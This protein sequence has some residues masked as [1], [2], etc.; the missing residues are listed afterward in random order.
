MA[1]L[2]ELSAFTFS[3]VNAVR[4]PSQSRQHTYTVFWHCGQ[5]VCRKTFLFLHTISEKR[6]KNLKS[7][8]TRNG[9]SPRTHG[10]T[11]RRPTPSA[12]LTH[13]GWCSTSPPTLRHTPFFCQDESLGTRE[14]ISS[15][16]HRARQRG[17]C[18]SHTQSH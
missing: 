11:R 6:L 5:R 8:L 16:Y 2:G 17:M 18:G 4:Y 10:N 1:L 14:Q 9:L 12:T 3:G 7:S 15:S 13:S